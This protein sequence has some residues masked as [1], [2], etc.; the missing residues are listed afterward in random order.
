[1]Q[2]IL[3]KYLVVTSFPKAGTEVTPIGKMSANGDNSRNTNDFSTIF[4]PFDISREGWTTKNSILR[5]LETQDWSD[6]IVVTYFF[7]LTS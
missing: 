7:L 3:F 6:A 1:M 5:T 2:N 4:L